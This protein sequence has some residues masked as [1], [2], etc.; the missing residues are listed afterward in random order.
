MSLDYGSHMVAGRIWSGYS[1]V[2]MF[3]VNDL[4]ERFGLSPGSIRERLSAVAGLVE[5]NIRRGRNNAI[6]LTDAGLAI[7]D[8]LIQLE[9]DGHTT[10]TAIEEMKNDGQGALKTAHQPNDNRAIAPV[11]IELVTELRARVDE[12]TR[13]IGYLQVKLDE[14]LTQVHEKDTHIR[15]LTAGPRPEPIRPNRLQAL[16]IA[17]LGR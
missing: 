9:R 6:L 1:S 15:A 13:M 4:S 10:I 16:R 2:N 14:A 12:Q 3:T 17:L 5:S 8:R 7:F 11:P